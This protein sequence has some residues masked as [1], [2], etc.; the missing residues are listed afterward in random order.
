MDDIQTNLDF[1]LKEQ[2]EKSVTLCVHPY[3]EAFIRKGIVS[4]QMRW[5]FKYGKWIKVNGTP[6][7][8]LTQFNFLNSKDEEIKL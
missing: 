4:C 6:S 3:I 8:H 1:I 2:N 7:Y 5:F